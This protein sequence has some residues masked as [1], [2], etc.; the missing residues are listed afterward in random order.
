MYADAASA[1][2]REVDDPPALICALLTQGIMAGTTGDFAGSRAELTEA[3]TVARG[4]GWAPGVRMALLNLGVLARLLGDVDKAVAFF[5][6]GRAL[7]E[8]AGDSY[9][10]GFYLTNLA[11]LALQQGDGSAAAEYCRQSLVIWR[12]LQD[13]HNVAMAVE[14]LAWAVGAQG[15]AE[16]AARLFGAAEALRELVGT[17][18]L[19]HWQ[20]DHDRARAAAQAALGERAFARAWEEGRAMTAEQAIAYGLVTPADGGPEG[21]HASGA[22][23][24]AGAARPAL[25]PREAEV[26]RL[27]ARGLTNRQIAE[28]LV[29]QVSTVG[30]HL[31]RIYGRLGLSG[32]AQLATWVSEHDRAALPGD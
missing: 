23:T 14:S 24:G 16:R 28:A 13:T 30:N 29:L 22:R 26:A 18:L 19:P 8:A 5:E 3:L 11:H 27:V 20:A 2:A 32:R 6:E 10:L 25:S 17:A 9:T 7:S 15:H 1:M 31:Q 21:G 12:D 4:A